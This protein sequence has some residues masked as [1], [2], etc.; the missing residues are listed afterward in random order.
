MPGNVYIEMSLWSYKRTNDASV[1][2]I[3]E[4]INDI[5]DKGGLHALQEMNQLN[6]KRKTLCKS[7]MTFRNCFMDDHG[8]R[9]TQL[10][11]PVLFSCT[12]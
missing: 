6:C 12:L 8:M 3:D 10:L 4:E 11:L 5:C 7:C 1:L 9:H 2:D